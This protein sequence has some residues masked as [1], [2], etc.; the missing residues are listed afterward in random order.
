[1][2]RKYQLQGNMYGLQRDSYINRD[3]ITWGTIYGNQVFQKPRQVW[4][5]NRLLWFWEYLCHFLSWK[6]DLRCI[7]RVN[8]RLVLTNKTS[9]PQLVFLWSSNLKTERPRLQVQSFAVLVW[10]SCSLFAV[11]R[12]DFKALII[13]LKILIVIFPLSSDVGAINIDHTQKWWRRQQGWWWRQKWW[14]R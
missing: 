4:Q 5:P 12:L 6:Y 8:K 11:L 7:W 10:S 13:E 2:L 1:M 14:R 9:P 3:V